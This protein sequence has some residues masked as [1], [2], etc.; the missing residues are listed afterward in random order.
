MAKPHGI[1]IPVLVSNKGEE[2]DLMTPAWD[3]LLENQDLF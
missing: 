3:G 1:D 2:K